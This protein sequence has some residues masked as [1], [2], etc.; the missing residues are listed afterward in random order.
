MKLDTERFFANGGDDLLITDFPTSTD[1][2]YKS[3]KNYKKLLAENVKTLR[4]F[5]KTLYAHNRYAVLLVF[6]GMDAS[7]KDGAVRHVFSGV[8]PQGIQVFSFKQPSS[9]ELNHDYLWRIHTRMPERGRFGIFNR[10]HYEEVLI[11]KQNPRVIEGQ[12]LPDEV[13]NRPHFWEERYQDIVQFEDYLYRNGTVILKFYLHLS[14]EEQRKRLLSRID[15]PDKNWKFEDS[16][17]EVRGKWDDYEA[18]YEKCLRKTSKAVAPWYVV[19]ADDKRNA[20]LIISQILVNE[21][22]RLPI[23]FPDVSD[24]RREKLQSMREQLEA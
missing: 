9:E 21:L 4:N 24:E 3:K 23:S 18:L 5:Q 11:A 22:T 20:R 14:Y 19:P 13:R 7:G 1:K 17:L 16:D 6:Q 8:N 10:S 12:R 15:N 2:L